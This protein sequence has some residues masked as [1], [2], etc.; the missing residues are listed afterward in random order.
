[1]S[2]LLQYKNFVFALI[3]H[4]VWQTSFLYQTTLMNPMLLEIY[5]LETEVSSLFYTISGVAFVLST[6]VAFMLRS[7]RIM[8]R[9][10]IM[11]S[12]MVLMGIASIV[13]TGDLR[14]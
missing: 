12:G 8:R 2:D 1:M 3:C 10:S 4:F 11:M 14:D 13:R 5:G 7:K 6:P 9:R